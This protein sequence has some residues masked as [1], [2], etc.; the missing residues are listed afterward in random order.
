MTKQ[1]DIFCILTESLN[2]LVF[3]F[4]ELSKLKW[5]T[6]KANFDFELF[7]NKK[8]KMIYLSSRDSIR[9]GGGVSASFSKLPSTKAAI[10]W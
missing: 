7:R 5:E 6:F 8:K 10:P 4:F 1:F 3:E 2:S 9:V